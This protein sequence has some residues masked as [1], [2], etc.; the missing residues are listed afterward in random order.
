MRGRP[1]RANHRDLIEPEI[2]QAL[3]AIP[4]VTVWHTDQPAD[5]LV[6]FRGVNLIWEIKTPTELGGRGLG[7]T[8]NERTFHQTW[9]GQVQ[10]ISSVDQAITEIE[11]L[12]SA[13]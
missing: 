10:I 11:R 8:K 12:A 5:L 13:G 3:R 6:G 9:T 7:L 2:V 1:S 4:G